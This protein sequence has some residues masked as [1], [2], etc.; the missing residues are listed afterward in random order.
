MKKK[1]FY[2]GDDVVHK[3]FGEGTIVEIDSLFET[4]TDNTKL[5]I[6]FEESDRKQIIAK[7]VKHA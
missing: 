6:V 7:F 4:V 1:E 2:V 5:T 3:L